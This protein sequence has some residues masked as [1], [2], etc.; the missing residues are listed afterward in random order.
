ML[1]GPRQSLRLSMRLKN[2][3][4]ALFS[5]IT[6]YFVLLCDQDLR[7]TLNGCPS[8]QIPRRYKRIQKRIIYV[9]ICLLEFFPR[10]VDLV[11]SSHVISRRNWAPRL[12]LSIRKNSLSHLPVIELHDWCFSRVSLMSV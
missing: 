2:R 12:C 1:S 10:S 5:T 9:S 11:C 6:Q 4:R 8:H 3:A 7:L